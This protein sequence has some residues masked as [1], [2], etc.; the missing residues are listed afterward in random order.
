MVHA[1]LIAFHAVLL[2]FLVLLL[3]VT[4]LLLVACLA[5]LLKR[6]AVAIAPDCTPRGYV[7]GAGWLKSAEYIGKFNALVAAI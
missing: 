3:L 5:N 2:L 4:R 1:G 7:W 6:S